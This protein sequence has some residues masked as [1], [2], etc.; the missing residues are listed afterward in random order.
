MQDPSEKNPN[1]S[2]DELETEPDAPQEAENQ[3]S[4]AGE[5]R[6][7]AQ[8]PNP[9]LQPESPPPEEDDTLYAQSSR[10]RP[11][12][13]RRPPPQAQPQ[14]TAAQQAAEHQEPEPLQQ[15]A[16]RPQA[17][18]QPQPQPTVQPTQPQV[19]QQD[20]RQTGRALNE[21]NN[22]PSIPGDNEPGQPPRITPN[23]KK[24]KPILII[25]GIAAAMALVVLVFIV[26][27]QQ[28]EGATAKQN[29][30]NGSNDMSQVIT[31]INELNNNVMA[32]DTRI[33]T[34]E[35]QQAAPPAASE[36]ETG[37]TETPTDGET[38]AM[39][40]T[41]EPPPETPAAAE[42]QAPDAT[43]MPQEADKPVDQPKPQP[44][45]PAMIQPQKPGICGRTP[46]LQDAILEKLNTTTCSK[47]NENELFRITEL[48]P[49]SWT[50]APRPGDFAGLVNLTMFTFAD[51]RPENEATPIPARTFQGLTGVQTA[52]LTVNGLESQAM[53]GM[54]ELVNLTINIPADG[55]LHPGALQHLPELENLVI[56]VAAPNRDINQ[57]DF[58]PIFD[59]MPRIRS[60]TISTDQ[61]AP[62]FKA[63]QFKNLQTL[64]NL[65]IRATIPPNDPIKDYWLP[66]SLFL[67]TTHMSN[68]DIQ[69]DG[70]GVIIVA[71]PDIVEHLHRL[72]ALSITFTPPDDLPPEKE[73]RLILSNQSPLLQE[74]TN[75]RQ[76]A[77][78]YT[79]LLQG[80]Q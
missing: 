4:P 64:Q 17:R 21:Q 38:A 69:I 12:L 57:R 71:P 29:P 42:E 58:F 10:Q 34:I 47:I 61:W 39:E 76:S 18:P 60:I 30:Q 46:E 68:I 62:R 25:G 11:N 36:P 45:E 65:N 3:D 33:T 19:H 75:G 20:L 5:S 35:A 9:T 28:E 44:T 13:G 24:G 72:R 59:R 37:Q 6:P 51:P 15:E 66:P 48:P 2:E 32:M 63:A 77:E 26:M 40:E 79:V 27:G 1:P 16:Q 52:E 78:G 8:R 23:Q 70:L 54:D 50:R 67:S 53:S 80:N 31:A 43:A 7:R 74:I 41:P 14:E 22:F 49:I 55:Q 73:L 56:N